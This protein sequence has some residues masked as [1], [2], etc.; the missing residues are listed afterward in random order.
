MSVAKVTVRDMVDTFEATS[1]IESP[2]TV[3]I[4]PKVS[5]VVDSITVHEGDSVHRGQV[6]VRLDDTDIQAMVRK[7]Q[8]DLAEAKARYVQAQV[9]QNPV[10]VGVTATIA[11]QV[12]AVSSATAGY[13]QVKQSYDATIAAADAAVTDAQG[14]IDVAAA[15]VSNAQAQ[16]RSAQ[17][18]LDDQTSKLTRLETLFKQKFYRRTG[19]RRPTGPGERA[20]RQQG[21]VANAML[22]SAQAALDSAKAQKNAASQQASI[23][24]DK[25]KADIDAAQAVLVQARASLTNA[26]A[27]TAQKP[28]Y[29]ANLQALA[30]AT[31]SAQA[32]LENAKAQLA[33]T[34][35]TAPIDGVITSRLQD[36]GS[37]G[38][39]NQPI[40]NLN[41]IHSVWVNMP[42][43][44]EQIAHT[45]LGIP[46]NVKVDSLPNISFTGDIVQ[47]NPAA[48]PTSRLFTVRIAV[49]NSRGLLKP[50]MFA[51][52][53]FVTQRL[54]NVTAIPPEGVQTADDGSTFSWVVGDDQTITKTPISVG[55]NNS[56]LVQVTTGLDPGERVIT[57][58]NGNL[59]DG[60]K[61]VIAGHKRTKG[62]AGSAGGS[63]G[64]EPATPASPN[65][66]G[67]PSPAGAPA[68][69]GPPGGG[70][71]HHHHHK[72]A[73]G[74]S[75]S[76][77]SPPA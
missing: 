37:M 16:I 62:P 66:P 61:V 65:A 26:R 29:V 8:A 2:E 5:E 68:G 58:F 33:Q 31:Q 63:Y 19:C 23:A 7:A 73:E 28:A 56:G 44:E 12:A 71:G 53:S 20:A 21:A 54:T 45:T 9:T 57:A 11:Q 75:D 50:G 24:R 27:N 32:D 25:G 13:N 48:D 3:K 74:A 67:S 4:S 40:L 41:S 14:R 6:L 59:K 30:A 38:T 69:A 46:V 17:A 1:N 49:D 70:G 77:G 55:E 42:V 15:G 22:L 51:R 72:N 35:L 39:P 76:A 43:P 18:N 60:Q 36:P 52:T 34:V 47:I 64:G 10:N